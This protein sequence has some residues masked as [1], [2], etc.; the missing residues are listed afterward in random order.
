MAKIER[1]N[2]LEQVNVSASVGR[3]GVN[4]S[5]DVLAVQALLKYALGERRSWQGVRF[6]EPTGAMDAPTMSLIRRYQM[7]YRKRL[8]SSISVDGRIDPAKGRAAFGRKGMWT[9]Q[10]LNSDAMEWWVMNGADG[11]GY[12]QKVGQ[13]FPA[14]RSVVGSNGVGTLGLELEGG[15]NGVGSLGLALE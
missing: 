11:A 10:L 7:S 14:F 1:F 9:I 13:A 15:S 6:P 12:I 3:T 4:L 8:G 5:S 2:E